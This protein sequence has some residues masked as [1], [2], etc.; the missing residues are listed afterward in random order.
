M[1][2]AR[3][4]IWVVVGAVDKKAVVVDD[5]VVIRPMLPV[6]AT[7]DHRFLDGAQAAV[8]AREMRAAF[9]EPWKLDGHERAPWDQA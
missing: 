6:M 8:I 1:P 2:F 5:E 3:V 4:P 7:V 9:A